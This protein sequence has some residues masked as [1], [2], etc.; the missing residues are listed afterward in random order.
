MPEGLYVFSAAKEIRQVPFLTPK[1]DMNKPQVNWPV[2]GVSLTVDLS[3]LSP[4]T[5][6]RVRCSMDVT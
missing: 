2:L 4:I 6:S 1:A 5:K 3:P